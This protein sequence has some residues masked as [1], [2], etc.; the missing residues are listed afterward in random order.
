MENSLK[1]ELRKSRIAQRNNL[2]ESTHDGV[3]C[4]TCYD[5]KFLYRDA[6]DM[7]F[8]GRDPRLQYA[9]DPVY[10]YPCP[11]CRMKKHDGSYRV[12]YLY[13]DCTFGTFRFDTPCFDE[14]QRFV[15]QQLQELSQ[16]QILQ[17]FILTGPS[18]S[19]KTHLVV[20]YI[21]ELA[22][23]GK[24]CLMCSEEELLLL[25]KKNKDY[26]DAG[27]RRALLAVFKH[28]DVLAVRRFGDIAA[29]WDRDILSLIITTLYEEQKWTVCITS[30]YGDAVVGGTSGS[31][32]TGGKTLQDRVEGGGSMYH[33]GVYSKLR[34]L[35]P[36]VYTIDGHDYREYERASSH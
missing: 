15:Y 5:I 34:Q 35:C 36:L 26:K 28:F 20:S 11:T 16:Q 10:A 12:P 24:R 8:T 22:E 4:D 13:E 27:T 18:G 30:Y 17:G 14:S 32:G 31:T 9:I 29:P 25:V 2:E 23:R 19:G 21:K 1:S 7:H 3:I 6:N 33:Y